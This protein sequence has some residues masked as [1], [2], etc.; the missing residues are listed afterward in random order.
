MFG[1][2]YILLVINI[3]LRLVVVTSEGNLNLNYFTG[4]SEIEFTIVDAFGQRL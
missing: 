1:A 2:V 4:F 3:L